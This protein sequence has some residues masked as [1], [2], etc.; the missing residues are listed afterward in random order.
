MAHVS[1]HES[2]SQLV[3]KLR[4]KS[5]IIKSKRADRLEHVIDKHNPDILLGTESW[6]SPDINNGEIFPS[7]YT[8]L[9]KDRL[10][11][12]HGGGVFQAIKNDL[13]VTHRHNLDT[14]C[15]IIWTHC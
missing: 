12:T 4:K 3:Q 6:L 13:L 10:T 1:P 2:K 5:Q 9:R 7:G 11:S 14:N 8:I 15:E